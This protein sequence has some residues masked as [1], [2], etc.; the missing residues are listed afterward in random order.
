MKLVAKNNQI[1]FSIE[2]NFDPEAQVATTDGI[3]LENLRRR[4]DLVYPAN[5]TLETT[6]TDN[7]YQAVLTIGLYKK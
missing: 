6:E 4:L 1:V 3:G 5:Y 2:N 7:V